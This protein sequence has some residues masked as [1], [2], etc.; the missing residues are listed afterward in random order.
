M[1]AI[2]TLRN[3]KFNNQ[4]TRTFKS[5]SKRMLKLYKKHGETRYCIDKIQQEVLKI[6]QTRLN[7]EQL[8][9]NI[10]PLDTYVQEYNSYYVIRIIHTKSLKIA[11]HIAPSG[12]KLPVHSHPD[13]VNALLVKTGGVEVQQ[14]SQPGFNNL[15]KQV[16]L[17]SDTCSAG[18]QRFFNLHSLQTTQPLNVFF[19]IRCKVSKSLMASFQ[20]S[21]HNKLKLACAFGLLMAP[22]V[23]GG[24]S[25]FRSH[26]ANTQLASIKNSETSVLPDSKR[27]DQ[28]ETIK[29]ANRLRS[30]SNDD[31]QHVQAFELYRMAAERHSA[32]AQYWLSIMY[33]KGMGVTDDDD[34]ALHWVSASADQNYEPAQELLHHLLVSDVALDC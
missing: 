17:T 33:L 7:T 14:T 19:S 12:R 23:S 25:D 3:H 21:F 26:Q 22:I 8:I 4:L 24:F 18:L 11:L 27:G 10:S 30:G 34:E 28:G 5:L 1:K 31:E 32:E 15:T 6:C 20:L 16:S 2:T 29:Q 9:K 13:S